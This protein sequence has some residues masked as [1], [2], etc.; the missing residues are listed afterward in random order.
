IGAHGVVD[1]TGDYEAY[2]FESW[3]SEVLNVT[4]IGDRGTA[5]QPVVMVYDQ[6]GTLQASGDA[7]GHDASVRLAV[8][9]LNYFTIVVGSKAGR[10]TGGVTR[11]VGRD[12]IA[13]SHPAGLAPLSSQVQISISPVSGSTGKAVVQAPALNP[14]AVSKAAIDALAH[15]N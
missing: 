13:K 9:D 8:R 3:K 5:L 10:T 6:Y 7:S 14:T 11:L 15:R 12:A 2:R 1:R 4:V